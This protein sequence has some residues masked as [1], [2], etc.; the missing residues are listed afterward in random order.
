MFTRLIKALLAVSTLSIFT[1]ASLYADNIGATTENGE[2][3]AKVNGTGISRNEFD[4]SFAAAEKQFASI[5]NQPGAG[6][7]NVKKEVLDQL[8]DLELMIQDAKKR[9]VV[10]DEIQVNT[11]LEAFKKQFDEQNTFSSF[12]EENSITE[13][14]MKSQLRKQLTIQ[15]LQKELVAEFTAKIT[16]S[17][18]ETKAFYDANVERFKQPEQV[19]ASHILIKVDSAGD[20]AAAQ[21]ARG[22]IEAIQQ[23]LKDGGDFAE[24]ARA[25]SGCPSSAQGGN[26]GFFGKGQMVKPFEEA[27]FSLKP[28]EISNIV[29]T[30]FG[31]H[32]IR[33]EEKRD[34]GAVPFDE[35][36]QRISDYLSQVKLDQL[37]QEYVKGLRDNAEITTLIKLD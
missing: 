25:N 31:Y 23:Q 26:L 9:G 33:L 18:S 1:A 29:E 21:K 6:Q 17:D 35:V 12:L 32:L 15:T 4:W 36:E 20:E 19:R 7:V 3:V 37:Q 24:L 2:F 8:V 34:A 14:I 10:A 28:G 30:S 11:G 22:D 27:A 16:T 13:E 5:G